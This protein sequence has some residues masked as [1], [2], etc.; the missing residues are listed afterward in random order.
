MR[1]FHYHRVRTVREA[2]DRQAGGGN[3]LA[4]GTTLIDLAKLGVVAPDHMVDLTPLAREFGAISFSERGLSIGAFATMA[5]VERDPVVRSRY[6]MVSEALGLSASPQIR[7]MA[8]IG[9][10]LLQRTRCT[11]FRDTSWSRCNRRVPGTGCQALA[12][13]A[14]GHAVLGG[15][16]S[17]VAL[18]HGDLAQPLIALDAMIEIVGNGGRRMVPLADLHRLPGS[19]PEHET[20]LGSGDIIVAVNL[21]ASDWF[22]RSTYTKLRDRASYEF[23][24]A[25]AAVA[26][27]LDGRRVRQ[28][29]IALGGVATIPWRARD[30]EQAAI[31]VTLDKEA[32][33][34]IAAVAFVDAL[35]RGESTYK[36]DLGQR[37]LIDALLRAAAKGQR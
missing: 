11:Y 29:R 22:S 1:S 32:A 7:N 4:G 36:I 31:G 34:R 25:A 18:Y 14:T 3:Y 2:L 30:A 23:A 37:A 19:N 21:P 16:D 12:G 20:Y 33:A 28:A 6:P 5:E 8:R 35:S 10:N 17:C 15:S 24:T 27:D 26:L 13:A 9:G